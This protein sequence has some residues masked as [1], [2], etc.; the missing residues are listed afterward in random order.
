MCP[1]RN[2]AKYIGETAR[3]LY[4]RTGEHNSNRDK[5]GSFMRKHMMEFHNGEEGDFVGRVT[6]TNKD[7]LTRQIRE[8]IL[9]RKGGNIMNTKSEWHQPVLFSISREV[10]RE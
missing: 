1:D 10:V 8:G 7:C 9:I 5:G 6:H 3:N 4:T 2:R